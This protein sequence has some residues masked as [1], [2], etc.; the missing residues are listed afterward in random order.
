MIGDDCGD[1]PLHVACMSGRVA[2][3]KELLQHAQRENRTDEVKRHERYIL[4]SLETRFVLTLCMYCW[5]L[6]CSCLYI[7]MGL[8][9]ACALCM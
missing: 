3:V 2:V 4:E 1:L 5:W 7:F 9:H 8:I 6:I